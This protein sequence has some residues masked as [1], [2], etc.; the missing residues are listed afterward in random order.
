MRTYTAHSLVTP[1]LATS[2]F[3]EPNQTSR[4]ARLSSWSGLFLALL[5]FWE[6]NSIPTLSLVT[7]RK[8]LRGKPGGGVFETNGKNLPMYLRHYAKIWLELSKDF[9]SMVI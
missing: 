5:K 7:G 4:H 2:L 3:S 6:W 8:P 1:D 9:A